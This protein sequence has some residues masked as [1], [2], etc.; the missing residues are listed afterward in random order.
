MTVCLQHLP[1]ALLSSGPS[2]RPSPSGPLATLVFKGYSRAPGVVLSAS[3]FV[4]G[5]YG[6]LQCKHSHSLLSGAETEVTEVGYLAQGQAA[7][8]GAGIQFSGT[9]TPESTLS[10]PYSCYSKCG[11]LDR[12]IGSGYVAPPSSGSFQKMQN[13]QICTQNHRVESGYLRL[14]SVGEGYRKQLVNGYSYS[15]TG[16]MG[17]DLLVHSR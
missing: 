16:R 15:Q 8:D 5:S 13:D 2:A 11:L 12:N 3:C 10:I 6:Q 7:E 4:L 9:W 17:S 14:G 1:R